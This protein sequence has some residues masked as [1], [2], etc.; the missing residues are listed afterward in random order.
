MISKAKDDPKTPAKPGERRSGSSQ[1]PK[2]SASGQRGGIKL[3]EANITTLENK[4]DEHNDKYKDAPS[5][6]VTMGQLK[7]VFRRG[8]GAFSTSHRP[9]VSSRDQWAIAR[10]NAFL[11]LMGTGKPKSAK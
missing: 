6:H 9:S 7:A 2:G 11:H 8:A 1:N 10:V 5:K 4:R 3:S